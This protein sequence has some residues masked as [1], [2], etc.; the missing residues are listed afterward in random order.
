MALPPAVVP[1]VTAPEPPDRNPAEVYLRGKPSATGRRGLQRSLERAAEILTGGVT[2]DAFAVNWTE[3]RYQHL[4]AMRS[5]LLDTD[6]KPATINHTLAAVRGTLREA[7]RLG[8][9]TAEDLARA[10]D[11]PNVKATML[12]AG[13]HVDVGEV[14][15]LFRAC[16]D[17]PVGA[18]D[19]A[20]LSLLY[21]C[22]LRR[23]E[24]VALLL[25]DY[26]QG[27]VTI[28]HGKG[29]KE[30]IVYCPA[31]GREAIDAWITRRGAWPGALVCPLKKGGHI[32]QRAMTAQAVLLRLQ[33]LAARAHVPP[34]SPH[35]L[36]RSFV[37]ELLDAG[38]DIS[39]VQQLAGHASVTTT[40]RYDRRP[41]E[42]K[43]RTA[44]LLHV[45]YA[46]PTLLVG[47]NPADLR[48]RVASPP[49][50]PSADPEPAD[51][52]AAGEFG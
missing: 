48:S 33:F 18:R 37:G 23:S 17:A 43:R 13:R 26:D 52:A 34:F 51:P 15:A 44:E 7:W 31:G 36:R 10:T 22:G 25:D 2:T 20:M 45:P 24:A 42:A 40:Q 47:N 16:G 27:A 6:A 39:S 30:R 9:L 35:D 3:V 46:A 41:E 5:L 50:A 4:M 29:R 11:V 1:I 19:A 28:H 14:T 38:A 8:Y 21:G 32:E 12:P 49:D